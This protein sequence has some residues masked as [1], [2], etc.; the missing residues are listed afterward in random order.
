MKY[1]KTFERVWLKNLVEGKIYEIETIILADYEWKTNINL[2]RIIKI[3]KNEDVLFF[4]MKTFLKGSLKEI[5]IELYPKNIKKLATPEQII[6]FETL[7]N[8]K[9][10]NL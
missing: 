2:G 4:N 7:E 3:Y 10:Y 5:E 8:Q 6:E 9:K 1:I